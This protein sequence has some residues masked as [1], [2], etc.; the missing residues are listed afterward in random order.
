MVRFVDEPGPTEREDAMLAYIVK[1][2]TF[3]PRTEEDRELVHHLSDLNL[4]QSNMT[5]EFGQE[6]PTRIEYFASTKGQRR[7]AMLEKAEM[8][9]HRE[10]TD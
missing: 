10:E 3:I 7:V 6:K 8:M 1:N 5:W 9:R 2:K 4:L